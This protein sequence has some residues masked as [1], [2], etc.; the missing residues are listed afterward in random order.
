MPRGTPA[1][2]S[3]PAR[4]PSP[5][6]D[7]LPRRL[8]GHLPRVTQVL[9]PW[10]SREEEEEI[11]TE[12]HREGW[13]MTVG[14]QERDGSRTKAWEQDRGKV[15]TRGELGREWRKETPGEEQAQGQGEGG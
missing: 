14:W 15:R 10:W 7:L 6:P 9:E 3:D 2:L 12:W 8:H 5:S 11:G 13:G 1:L 4:T